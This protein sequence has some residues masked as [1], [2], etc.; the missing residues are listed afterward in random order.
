MM[1]RKNSWDEKELEIIRYY[2]PEGAVKAQ[3]ELRKA[4][5]NRTTEAIRKR[6]NK[7]GV[8]SDKEFA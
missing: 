8:Y 2:Y 6:A 3:R 1:N 5:F 7:I 4:G